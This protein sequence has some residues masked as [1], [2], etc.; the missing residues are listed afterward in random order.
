MRMFRVVKTVC[1]EL[2][3][4]FDFEIGEAL[5]LMNEEDFIITAKEYI[6]QARYAD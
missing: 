1:F 4:W 2:S 5:K 6:H 3:M